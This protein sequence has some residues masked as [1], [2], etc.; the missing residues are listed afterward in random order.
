MAAQV[1]EN[2]GYADDQEGQEAKFQYRGYGKAMPE[3]FRTGIG[4]SQREY[5][6]SANHDG[7]QGVKDP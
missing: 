7:L 6:T 1:R 4:P 5:Y 3:L 2:Q